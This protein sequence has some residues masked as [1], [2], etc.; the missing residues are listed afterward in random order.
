MGI[1]APVV[2][3]K[4]RRRPDYCI[5]LGLGAG[6]EGTFVDFCAGTDSAKSVHPFLIFQ[7]RTL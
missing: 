6:V 5:T 1:D 2:C 4:M 7:W 3:I